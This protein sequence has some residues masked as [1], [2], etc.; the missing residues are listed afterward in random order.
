MKRTLTFV[1]L[2]L[3]AL[4]LL[5]QGLRSQNRFADAEG[6]RIQVFT[7]RTMY[8]SGEKVLFSALVFNSA[9]FFTAN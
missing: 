3:F 2:V 8:V 9:V 4:M 5:C 6:E 7:D 1:C